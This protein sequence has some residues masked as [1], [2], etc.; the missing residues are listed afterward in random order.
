MKVLYLEDVLEQAEIVE[1]FLELVGGMH[2]MTHAETF[3]ET[4]AK[5]KEERFDVA[6]LDMEVPDGSGVDLVTQVRELAPAMP[7]VVLTASESP[8]LGVACLQAGAQDFLS[9][10]EL[11]PERLKKSLLYAVMRSES[12]GPDLDRILS[13]V[14]SLHDGSYA[15]LS[16]R[17]VSRYKDILGNPKLLFTVEHWTLSQA[18]ANE[19]ATSEQVL[20]L[21]AHSLSELCKELDRG[22]MNHLLATSELV[23]LATVAFMADKYRESA[24]LTKSS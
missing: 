23:A 10:R 9:K 4:R 22:R 21:H 14:S 1:T 19:G 3:A 6:L 20:A 8:K 11:T 24:V 12:E 5:L 17:S 15:E 16:E 13:R 18:L 7:I 2:Q